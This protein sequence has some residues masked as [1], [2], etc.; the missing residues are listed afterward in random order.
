VQLKEQTAEV[1]KEPSRFFWSKNPLGYI[2]SGVNS[3]PKDT[4]G[5]T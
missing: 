1:H 3:G 2:V 4:V 5:V